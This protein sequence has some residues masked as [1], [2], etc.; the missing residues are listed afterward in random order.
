MK[1]SK[2][3]AMLKNYILPILLF[4]TL[5]STQLKAQESIT[6]YNML[7]LPQT[8]K[9]NPAFQ[10]EYNGH[11]GGM[12][13]MITPVFGQVTPNLDMSFHSSSF[14]YG[15]FIYDGS[16]MFSD[17]LIWAFNSHKDAL[18]FVDKLDKVNHLN[19]NLNL[20]IFN[21]GFRTNN[22]Y[23]NV[24]LSNKTS[25]HTSFPGGLV[26]LIVKGNASP[27][28]SPNIDL[29]GFGVDFTNYNEFGVGASMNILPELRVGARL[30]GLSGIA[31][32]ETVKS[33]LR[34]NTT[35]N[36]LLLE[37]DM[38]IRASQPAFIIEDLY[39][40][41]EGDS[42]VSETTELET[43]KII[44]NLS[45]PLANPGLAIDFGA[46]YQVMP[47]LKVFASV[48]DLGFITWNT[49]VAE[50]KGGGKFRF[51]GIDAV[52]YID[53][54]D[55][56]TDEP[57]FGETMQDS[58]LKVFDIRKN[59][60]EDYKTWL[61][62]KVYA[63]GTYN[64]N[65][66]ISFGALLRGT[67][68]KGDLSSAVSLSANANTGHISAS[69]SY[70]IMENN[71]DNIGI[72]FAGRFGPIQMYIV[73]DHVLEEVFPQNARDISLRMGMNWIIGYKKDR[74]ALIE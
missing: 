15:D 53:D 12:I 57:D 34:L 37:S 63:G 32:A 17:S 13:T 10:P 2:R 46:E 58:I 26:E 47:E 1:I 40:N 73:S 23:W 44:S 55:D 30:K 28:I 25:F 74:A 62:T 16:D 33:D 43:G 39:Y 70:T 36:E 27:D 66:A 50:I 68:Y 56:S 52:E 60:V 3:V 67:I 24:N 48:T 22:I 72:G 8:S 59:D 54:N 20:N 31:N 5:G 71:F 6:M 49:N 61:P 14:A 42:L 4:F 64:I 45:N 9:L 69:I 38:H 7:T 21:F 29:S 65:N 18:K 51:E 41:F 35:D 11:V 19:L